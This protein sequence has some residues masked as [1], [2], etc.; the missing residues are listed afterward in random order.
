MVRALPMTH[1][2]SVVKMIGVVLVA[3]AALLSQSAMAFFT[4]EWSRASTRA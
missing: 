2:V 3:A 4:R 1:S